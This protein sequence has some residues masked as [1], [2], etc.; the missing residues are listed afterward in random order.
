MEN[1]E[2]IQ[3]ENPTCQ[4]EIINPSD[5][6]TVVGAMPWVSLA[7]LLIGEGKYGIQPE[8]DEC[9]LKEGEG[10][11]ILFGG[12]EAAEKFSQTLFGK[13]LAETLADNEIMTKVADIL[14]TFFYG[15]FEDRA[16]YRKALDCIDDP[17]KREEFI[18]FHHDKQRSSMNNIGSCAATWVKRLRIKTRGEEVD[19]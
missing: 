11:L 6:C 16:A 2:A 8:S 3:A 19:F 12:N 10:P 15:G 1:Q 18:D 5:K 9:E 7:V 13:S 4:W 17:V 14:D